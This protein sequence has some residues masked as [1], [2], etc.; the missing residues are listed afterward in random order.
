MRNRG[1]HFL[2]TYLVTSVMFTSCEGILSGLYDEMPSEITLTE[3]QIYVDAS[4]WDAWQYINMDQLLA[5]ATDSTINTSSAIT[6]MNI[7]TDPSPGQDSTGIYTYWFDVLGK[8]L[9]E[10]E[11]R[12]SYSTQPQ[13]EPRAWTIAIHREVVRTNRCGVL[14]TD[15]TSM[16]DLPESSSAFRDAEFRTD[17]WSERDVWVMQGQML[18][19]LIGCQGIPI[20]QVLSGWYTC[21]IPPMPPTYTMNPRVYVL[22]LANGRHAALQLANHL[23]PSGTKCCFTINYRYPY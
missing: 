3:R 7:P 15:Y 2:A 12:G 4:R 14:Q 10:Y 6:T 17:E 22:R 18:Q 8:G 16:A 13:P 5:S 21:H 19:G 1:V 20:N 9:S 11:F 23:S